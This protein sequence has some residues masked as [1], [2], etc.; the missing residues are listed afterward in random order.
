MSSKLLRG[1]FILTLGTILSKVLGLFYIIPFY[2]IIDK[3]DG[4][5]FLFIYSLY[6]FY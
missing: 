1:T 5:L 6:D 3:Y 2:A 4:T